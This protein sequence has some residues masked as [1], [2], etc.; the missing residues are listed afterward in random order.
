MA[1]ASE[2]AH[3]SALM[4]S[5]LLTLVGS[6]GACN[7]AQRYAAGPPPSPDLIE[8]GQGRGSRELAELY[9]A[10]GET[11]LGSPD[12]RPLGI[13]NLVVSLMLVVGSFMLGARRKSTTWFLT[14]ALAANL[15]F[16]VAECGLL[17][18]R[19]QSQSGTLARRLANVVVAQAPP[20]HPIDAAIALR[21]A[22]GA[23]TMACIGFSMVAA[24]KFAF[25]AFLMARARSPEVA[26]FLASTPEE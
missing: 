16:I 25:H 3:R 19:V 20:D 12:R 26:E 9:A 5:T 23:I 13:A 7:G 17:I 2:R 4:L 8:V 14:N 15:V 11:Y 10:M 6:C 22:G 21:D 18:A 1:Q 24:L